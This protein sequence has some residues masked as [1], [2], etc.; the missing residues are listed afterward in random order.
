MNGIF[1]YYLF[2]F[3]KTAISRLEW[4]VNTE[5]FVIVKPKGV[6][7]E[8]QKFM[9]TN[10]LIMNNKSKERDCIY[11][12]GQTG[13]GLATVNRGQWYNMMLFMHIMLRH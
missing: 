4:D 2:K 11:F 3:R 13:V 8:T 12:D 9:P 7:G 6:M 10:E 5:Q 1:T